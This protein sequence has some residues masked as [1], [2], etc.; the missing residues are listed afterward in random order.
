MFVIKCA[1]KKSEAAERLDYT[2]R[3]EKTT[4]LL[5]IK[6]SA[7]PPVI[8]VHCRFFTGSNNIINETEDGIF[9]TIYNNRLYFLYYISQLFEL[10]PCAQKQA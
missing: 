1:D 7:E 4:S 2:F 9:T 6:P 3:L 10:Q 8:S 5:A